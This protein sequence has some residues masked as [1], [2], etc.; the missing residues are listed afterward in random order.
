MIIDVCICLY[1]LL[2]VSIRFYMFLLFSFSCCFSMHFILILRLYYFSVP[3]HAKFSLKFLVFVSPRGA[4]ASASL[5]ATAS[6][7]FDFR[8]LLYLSGISHHSRRKLAGYGSLR[9]RVELCYGIKIFLDRIVNNLQ[10]LH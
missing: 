1:M 5:L 2:Y 6:V 8:L 3:C 10:Q 4:S 7:V 9:S